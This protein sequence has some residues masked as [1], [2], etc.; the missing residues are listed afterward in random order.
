MFNKSYFVDVLS[1]LLFGIAGAFIVKLFFL[2]STPQI[3]TVNITGMVDSF[4][5]ETAKQ[6]IS[7]DEM[8]ARTIRFSEALTRTLQ[9]FS[10]KNHI[11]LVPAEA[12]IAGAPDITNSARAKIKEALSR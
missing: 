7:A 5:K 4:E 3:A 10:T 9:D 8:K 6:N 11:I 12:V 2:S 1:Q